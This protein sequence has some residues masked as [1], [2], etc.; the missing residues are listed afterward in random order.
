MKK[1]KTLFHE[2][3]E[4]LNSNNGE[5]KLIALGSR[6]GMGK[7][8]FSL[9][10]MRNIVEKN[11]TNVLFFSLES[12]KETLTNILCN[13]WELEH[14][15]LLGNLYIDVTASPNIN[16]IEE[17]ICEAN[18]LSVVFIDYIE[19][20]RD[21]TSGSQTAILTKLKNI[22]KSK[23][24][25]IVYTC[26]LT[27]KLEQRIDKRPILNDLDEF[28]Q[29]NADAIFALYR[30]SY[31]TGDD[32][33]AE[34]RALK[35]PS[36]ELLEIP[37]VFDS[38]TLSLYYD[39]QFGL[40]DAPVKRVELSVHTKMSDDVST[41]SV[42]EAFDFADSC[43]HKA[44]AF[45][46]YNNVQDFPEIQKISVK[47]DNLKVIYGARILYENDSGGAWATTLLI[48]NQQGVKNLYKLISS[49]TEMENT[50]IA[51]INS[52]EQYRE[53]LLCSACGDL[54]ELYCAF[55]AELPMDEIKVIAQRYDYFEIF[56][57]NDIKT[58]SIYQKMVKLGKELNIPVVATG[59]CHY[60]SKEDEIC[61]RVVKH[62]RGGAEDNYQQYL[63]N[64]NDML[65]AFAY[66]GDDAYDVV[67][68]NS[69]LI[70][71][72]IE[73]VYPISEA[74]PLLN[75][76]D[77]DKCIYVE[78][79]TVLSSIYGTNPP[80]IIS[81]RYK[82]EMDRIVNNGYA[83]IYMLSHL[84][85]K[86][87]HTNGYPTTSRGAV[88]SSFIAYLL[89]IT[90]VNPLPPHYYCKNCKHIEFINDNSVYSGDDLP[91]KNCP[92]CGKKLSSDGHNIPFE[93]FL[94][95]NG[96]KVPDIDLNFSESFHDD[97]LIYLCDMFG[98]ERILRA[99]TISS[100]FEKISDM[101]VKM[102]EEVT[103]VEFDYEH[104]EIIKYKIDNIKRKEGV[105]PCGVFIIPEGTEICD[106]TPINTIET[107]DRIKKCSH[108]SFHALQDCIYK[109][110]ILGFIPLEILY[111]LQKLTG[112][113]QQDID[114]NDP[115]LYE[116]FKDSR[117][118]GIDSDKPATLGIP[119]FETEFVRNMIKQ[120]KPKCFGDL[121]KISGLSHGTAVWLNNAEELL[122]NNICEFKDLAASRDDVYNY[123]KSCGFK[124][125]I[126]FKVSEAVR[127]GIFE[128]RGINKEPEIVEE[129]KSHNIPDW[130]MESLCKIRYMF[131]K[132]HSV[133]YVK[134]ALTLAWYKIYY[135]TEFY[136]VTF[137][138]RFP[139]RD[140]SF[141]CGGLEAINQYLEDVKLPFGSEKE[142]SID[143]ELNLF[144]EC[145]ERGI[146]L[147][148][149]TNIDNC[150][151]P[152]SI[153][154]GKI[155][156]NY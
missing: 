99:G 137:N 76:P 121:V 103:G 25:S 80:D 150:S 74:Y 111:R 139:D 65:N 18:N 104:S 59:D 34:L 75:I 92:I 142:D 28:T 16:Y 141:L 101:Y 38:K 89:G 145:A 112:T 122:K 69:N 36:G 62:F 15:T 67:V 100:L 109:A 20:I 131:P 52:I 81:K 136:A 33:I 39:I 68:T 78:S 56:P 114:F 55:Q 115:K 77:A 48:K 24:V 91:Q 70:A 4:I 106:F 6:P 7:T 66:L 11:E 71:D 10:L 58:R 124:R 3:D 83:S 154:N 45:T 31:Y 8:T 17:K 21:F 79:S 51:H 19:L 29:K 151:E 43:N 86:H 72:I 134:T 5:G 118:I 96:D 133:E 93:T 2:I 27:S 97:T 113:S 30:P 128:R 102:Y 37:L 84:I 64:T 132:A 148:C 120:I 107:N 53:H 41:I 85:T 149:N 63:R 116:L 46:N 1:I 13:K 42:Q 82:T 57:T 32:P 126:A 125:H 108:F 22:C 127:K 40:D 156:L 98:E 138:V 95:L 61:R 130:Y 23:N 147:E 117:S 47:Y 110:D 54:S 153:S 135:P 26:N 129:F 88:G 105:H 90:N 14:K 60:C 44:I 155:L 143:R 94:G 123:L 73:K 87:S 12:S 140:Y 35:H 49:M 152:Y 144:K 9:N 119:E 50:K 146:V